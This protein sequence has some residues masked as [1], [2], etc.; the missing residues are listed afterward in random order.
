M[1]GNIIMKSE[2]LPGMIQ[3]YVEGEHP[4]PNFPEFM[5]PDSIPGYDN[6]TPYGRGIVGKTV[7]PVLPPTIVGRA[8]CS[9]Q[10]RSH[11]VHPLS[12]PR[13]DDGNGTDSSHDPLRFFG[14]H[15][16][17]CGGEPVVGG[18]V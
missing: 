8:I 13:C 15:H 3:F 2:S 11:E 10:R 9:T 6:L 17:A 7:G 12:D 18:S 14:Q 4:F 5:A 16:R 1:K